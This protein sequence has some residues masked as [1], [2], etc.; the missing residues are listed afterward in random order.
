MQDLARQ[1]DIEML[2]A[3]RNEKDFLLRFQP[4]YAEAA[5]AR[6]GTLHDFAVEI[7]TTAAEQYPAIAANANLLAALATQYQDELKRVL[8]AY[9]ERGFDNTSGVWGEL[10]VA[11]E[12]WGTELKAMDGESAFLQYLLLRRWEKDY[13]RTQDQKYS[14]HL[15]ATLQ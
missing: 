5:A 4:K 2:Q 13:I 10:D 12:A 1:V 6:A 11:A 3:R 8:T 15:Y 9:T 7:E 14:D